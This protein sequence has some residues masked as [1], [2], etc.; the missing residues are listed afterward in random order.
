MDQRGY[1]VDPSE[2]TVIGGV[3]EKRLAAWG[4]LASRFDAISAIP[5]QNASAAA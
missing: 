1:P 5:S 2:Q 3:P 4:A